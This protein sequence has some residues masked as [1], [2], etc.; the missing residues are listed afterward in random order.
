M[1]L[2]VEALVEDLSHGE[3]LQARHGGRG[4]RRICE[5]ENFF[6]RVGFSGWELMDGVCDG[7]FVIQIWFMASRSKEIEF[8]GLY[9]R[10]PHTGYPHSGDHPM[11]E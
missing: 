6:F 5:C 9:V 11:H 8:L 1:D 2:L 10:Q 3:G 7:S 4:R